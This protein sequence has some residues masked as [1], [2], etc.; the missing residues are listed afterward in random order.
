MSTPACRGTIINALVDT[1]VMITRTIANGREQTYA[2][3]AAETGF[4]SLVEMTL[5]T[6]LN[7]FVASTLSQSQPERSL[8]SGATLLDV[9]DFSTDATAH[10]YAADIYV[11]S[12]NEREQH[13]YFEPAFHDLNS[14]AIDTLAVAYECLATGSI[15]YGSSRAPGRA[16]V[17]PLI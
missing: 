15:D 12:N 8:P 5:E 1:D 14:D 17:L 13:Y 7:T 2:D 16:V 11:N 4:D 10:T 3:D 9:T 6:A